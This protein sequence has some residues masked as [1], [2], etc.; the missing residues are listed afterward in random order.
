MT[1]KIAL[2][3][4]ANK[5]LGYATAQGLGRGGVTVLVGA[6]SPE[7]GEAAAARLRAEGHDAAF[8]HLDVTDHQ[9][10]AAAKHVEATYGSLDI[11]VNNAGIALAYGNRNTGGLTV[12]ATRKTSRPTCS[13]SSP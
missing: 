3:T 5:S 9:T 13:A 4:G 6:R 8:V 1:E 2:I 12:A 7:R 10:V 11:P